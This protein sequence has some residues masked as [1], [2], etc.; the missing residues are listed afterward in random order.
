[1]LGV[2]DLSVVLEEL[3]AIRSHWNPM[4]LKL[5]LKVDTLDA[6]KQQCCGDPR[7]CFQEMLKNY[8]KKTNPLPSWRSLIE[9]LKSPTVD[10]PQLA[11]K[12]EKQYCPGKH[13]T[14]ISIMYSYSQSGVY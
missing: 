5:G 9:A 12:L 6:I 8:L 3:F 7:D 4:G 10:Q 11:K 13:F 2:D 1:M 14:A